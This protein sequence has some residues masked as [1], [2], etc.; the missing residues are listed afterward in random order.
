V[1]RIITIGLLVL[2]ITILYCSAKP[3]AVSANSAAR[4]GQARTTIKKA[5]S[6]SKAQEGIVL[7][8]VSDKTSELE[9]Q[10]TSSEAPTRQTAQANPR[11]K[12]LAKTIFRPSN[13]LKK[14]AD[15]LT[16]PKFTIDG[17]NDTNSLSLN[18]FNFLKSFILNARTYCKKNNIFQEHTNTLAASYDASLP[19]TQAINYRIKNFDKATRSVCKSTLAKIKKLESQAEPL[20]QSQKTEIIESLIQSQLNTVFG[21]DSMTGQKIISFTENLQD[22]LV[23][24]ALRNSA[25][26]DATRPATQRLQNIAKIGDAVMNKIGQGQPLNTKFTTTIDD[27]GLYTTSMESNIEALEGKSKEIST[28]T[29]INNKGQLVGRTL[30]V[31]NDDGAGEVVFQ[32]DIEPKTGKYSTFMTRPL[33]EGYLPNKNESI[34]TGNRFVTKELTSVESK[35]TDLQFALHQSITLSKYMLKAT[36]GLTKQVAWSIIN[37]PIPTPILLGSLV[38]LALIV[39]G[40]AKLSGYRYSDP[41]ILATFG[42]V[43][44]MTM[45]G[46]R[47][48][49]SNNP[50]RVFTP[51]ST[52]SKTLNFINPLRTEEGYAV[53]PNDEYFALETDIG[54]GIVYGLKTLFPDR[55]G[56]RL[57]PLSLLKQK[58]A[59]A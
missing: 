48:L 10:T 1:K 11:T 59:I 16:T 54:K 5:P 38:P 18:E 35:M 57:V 47:G 27:N 51:G 6:I 12:F 52:I 3:D 40:G 20:S 9:S 55:F 46:R 4:V 53:D 21:A 8:D 31:N 36:L 34:Q 42:T 19:D 28:K 2:H 22:E 41:T 39:K 56:D 33:I 7:S 43:V 15:S 24:K 29:S 58:E 32:T 30:T 25:I 49:M 50:N 37:H 45:G 23:N 26:F 14:E 13:K 17:I 44:D